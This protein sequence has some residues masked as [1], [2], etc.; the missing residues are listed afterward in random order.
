MKRLFEVSWEVCNKVGGIHTVLVSKVSEA[1]KE[2]NDN[3]W[4]LGP[5]LDENSEFQESDEPEWQSIRQGLCARNL[6]CRLGR[7]KI[8]GSPKVIL[9]DFRN[10]YD[11]KKLLFDYWKDF[12]VDSYF[13]SHD[14]E[15]PVSFATAAAEVIEIVNQSFCSTERDSTLAHFHEWM[16]G[17]GALRLKKRVPEIATV[18]TTHATVMGRAM[19][20]SGVDIYNNKKL[21]MM[22]DP[23]AYGVTAKH[24]L[25][26]ASARESDSFTAVSQVTAEECSVILNKSPDIVLPNG[27]TLPKEP[28][29]EENEKTRKRLSS[30]AEKFLGKKLPSETFFCVTSGRYE[31]HNKG[32]D[33]L[34]KSAGILDKEIRAQDQYP[35]VVIWILVAGWHHGVSENA[36]HR[37]QSGNTEIYDTPVG[38]AT[39]K[40]HDEQ[41]DSI[42]AACHKENLCNSKE[43]K[44]NIIFCPAYLEGHDG[45]FDMP[46]YDILAAND[47]GLF[48]SYYEP[49]GYTPQESL[50]F[51]VPTITS[52]VAGFGRWA[53]TEKHV[54][55]GAI[56]V[57]E[58]SGDS[59]ETV[60][61][62]L[63][64]RMKEF[65]GLSRKSLAALRLEGKEIAKNCDWKHFYPHYKE[66]YRIALN[67][68]H[69]RR[70]SSIPTMED[71]GVSLSTPDSGS[72]DPHY[73][74]FSKPS[75]L[76]K[77]IA[78]LEELAYNL[79]WAWHP[80][81]QKL[82]KSIDAVLWKKTKSNPVKLLQDV[83]EATL[84]QK[85][86]SAEFLGAYDAV[87]E[88]FFR[89][90]QE[91]E[92]FVKPSHAITDNSPVA[93]F[94]MEF[95][96]HECLPIYSG[97]LGILSGDH[98]KA[99]SDLNI[100]II[101]VGLMYKRGYFKQRIS[102]NGEQL[103][104]YPELD[105]ARMP[106]KSLVDENNEDV[107]ICIEVSDRKIYVRVWE[108]NVGR[109][110]LYLLDSDVNENN[111]QD[112][113]ITAKLYESSR[114][115][116]L[117]QEIILGWGGVRLIHDVLKIKPALFHLN[118][119]HSG[120]LLIERVNR[121]LQDGL[122]FEEAREVVK[123]SSIFTTHTPVP[124][125]NEEF[126]PELIRR[127][128][129][130][131][132][133]KMGIHWNQFYELGCMR[134][135]DTR[136][137]FSMTVMALKMCH[138]SNGVSKLHGET[139]RKMWSGIWEGISP[140]EIPISSVTNGIHLPT[141]VGN[142][143]RELFH[144]SKMFNFEADNDNEDRWKEISQ[145][146]D[147][148]LWEA[149]YRQKEDLINTLKVKIVNDYTRRGEDPDL[150]KVTL[151]Q[152]SPDALVIGFARRFA[153]YKRAM[154]LV[155]DLDALEEIV[156]NPDRPVLIVVAGKAH[157]NDGMGKKV[158]QDIVNSSKCH[159]L[160]GRLIFVENYDMAFGKK[161]TQ[162][163]DLWLNLPVMKHEASGTS[164]MKVAPNGGLNFS[165]PDGWW[166]EAC[167]KDAG[168]TLDSHVNYTNQEH[169]DQIDNLSLMTILREEVIPVYFE[170]N[171]KNYSPRWVKLIKNSLRHLCPQFSA[172]RMLREYYTQM[173]LPT[174]EH[175][176]KLIKDNFEPIKALAEWKG[177]VKSRFHTLRVVQSKIKGIHGDE[178][179]LEGEVSLSLKINIGE[180][181]QKEIRPEF[182]IGLKDPH[183]SHRE[184]PQVLA[185]K[186]LE[187]QGT[188]GDLIEYSLSHT[189]KKNG[190]YY[191][192][193]R[194]TPCHPLLENS[195]ELGLV[196]WI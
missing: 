99:A 173:Y 7:W 18:F 133:Q 56:H 19:A 38:I 145:I 42:L 91:K 132:I 112:R 98:M 49:W 125:G 188:Q 97:G 122:S 31:F 9:V 57:L 72:R 195:Q 143:M 90:L 27:F 16:C 161:L 76:P 114:E 86:K 75:Q 15:E 128:F 150:I 169:Q 126:D 140:E 41:H 64:N 105:C 135:L 17:A 78:K 139:S 3:Y 193:I 147:K 180:M 89:Y 39:H 124:A 142:E 129:S 26:M 137:R 46:Y 159:N 21:S 33:T 84:I 25:E 1:L 160:R 120:F 32:F 55:S 153:T 52:D 192:G 113:E 59:E 80:G 82:F 119:G 177:N 184:P 30:I 28:S 34:I 48:P 81:A 191:Y 190:L 40:L 23:G 51:G 5:L 189:V 178:V 108:V 183:D 54:G 74:F 65:C 102:L 37:I 2:F 167:M 152:L 47:L 11:C 66:A 88:D 174:A 8:P 45:I 95:G 104:E 179:N 117:I 62:E 123:A 146:D 181:L 144:K 44:V 182:V 36:L 14:Y 155:K 50:T 61:N 35:P 121:Y 165:V 134:P 29:A 43:N 168:W 171:K 186:P 68:A 101:G 157:P 163:V 131:T 130:E 69:A 187:E 176:D 116:R 127:Y 22:L 141:W 10:R 73:R 53:K 138:Q 136:S 12:N 92:K 166:A 4:M 194:V 111:A 172:M 196:Y 96:L 175:A 118:E 185:L 63:K 149:H 151:G 13:S 103:E 154:M 106:I 100:P 85:S 6:N 58:R 77:E 93:Y 71:N 60:V 67:N 158:L 156:G 79:F 24:S 87:M 107:Q 170:R 83:D 110:K 20:N 164:G 94:S 109:T 162:G 115:I 70:H 148:E